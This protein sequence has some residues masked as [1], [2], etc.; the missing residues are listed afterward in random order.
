MIVQVPDATII[1]SRKGSTKRKRVQMRRAMRMV[2]IWVSK[3]IIPIDLY[4]N[5][6][7]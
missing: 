5:I 4:F 1:D 3:M 6:Q 2:Y 7:Q